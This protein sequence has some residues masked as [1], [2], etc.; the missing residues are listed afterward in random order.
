MVWAPAKQPET[1]TLDVLGI[2]PL[3]VGLQG[4]V[5]MHGG[6]RT[7]CWDRGLPTLALAMC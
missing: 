2:S 4:G 1:G 3:E 5:G 7:R 6:K